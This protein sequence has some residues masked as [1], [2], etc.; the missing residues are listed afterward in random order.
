MV[1][2]SLPFSSW[3]DRGSLVHPKWQQKHEYVRMTKVII[4]IAHTNKFRSILKLISVGSLSRN[5]SFQIKCAILILAGWVHT[6]C[7]DAEV[8]VL[9]YPFSLH[10]HIKVSF[11]K[12]EDTGNFL[13]LQHKYSKYS[14]SWAENLKKLF[15]VV[16]GKFKFFAQDSRWFG[17]SMLER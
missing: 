10:V 1:Q 11:L 7:P 9:N 4:D 13:R 12:S 6:G 15:T 2:Y 8:Y 17:I 5:D 16:G 14:K 3:L